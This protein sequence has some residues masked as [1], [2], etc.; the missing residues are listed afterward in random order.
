MTRDLRLLVRERISAG[1]SDAET[2]DYIVDR[3]GEF[4]LLRPR[5]AGQN[6]VLWLA[7]PVLL[8]IGLGLVVL[9]LRGRAHAGG[10]QGPALDD[11]EKER[12]KTLLEE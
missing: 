5:V 2:M 6:L 10:P 1:D 4:V 11:A 8:L 3:Y 9:F 7:G 12:L